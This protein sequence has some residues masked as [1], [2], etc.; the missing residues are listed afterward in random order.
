MLSLAGEAYLVTRVDLGP[1]VS[2]ID[3]LLDTHLDQYM[4]RWRDSL[5]PKISRLIEVYDNILMPSIIDDIEYDPTRCRYSLNIMGMDAE[6]WVAPW[7]I[8]LERDYIIDWSDRDM[9]LR[10]VEYQA[11]TY[12]ELVEELFLLGYPIRD[13]IP[14][15]PGD[16]LHHWELLPERDLPKLAQRMPCWCLEI[17]YRRLRN[18]YP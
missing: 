16:D 18:R 7:G 1:E 13:T 11:D 12:P 10:I 17:M 8:E 2:L 5:L 3:Y 14:D 15:D 6:C 4:L 9:L